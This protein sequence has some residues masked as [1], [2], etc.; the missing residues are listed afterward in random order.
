[1][2]SINRKRVW[3]LI[4]SI[5]M[6]ASATFLL[7]SLLS[8]PPTMAVGP[9]QAGKVHCLDFEEYNTLEKLVACIDDYMPY[10]WG[11]DGR[12]NRFDVPEKEEILQWRK[13]I[14]RMMTDECNIDLSGYSWGSDFTVTTFTDSAPYCVLMETTYDT[15]TDTYG[16]AITRFTHGWGTFIYNR[17]YCRDL[18]ISAPH[19]HPRDERCT[20]AEA[21]GIFKNTRSRTFLMA[22]THR[23]ANNELSGCCQ[24]D[25]LE[26]DSAHNITHTFHAT[27]E[28]LK[29]Y[30]ESQNSSFYHLQFHG[31][32]SCCDNCDVYLSHG[33][34]TPPK[35]GDPILELRDNLLVYNPDW[36]IGVPGDGTCHLNGTKNV[37][38]RLLNGVP[39]DQICD[40]DISPP[41]YSGRFIHIEQ[42]LSDTARCLVYRNPDNWFPAINNTWWEPHLSVTKRASPSP[43]P[44]KAKMT[45]ILRVTNTGEACASG[46][47]ITDVLPEN[48][49]FVS[50]SDGGYENNGVITWS[51]LAVASNASLPITFAVR[52]PCTAGLSITND[53]YRVVT[54]TQGITTGWGAPVTTTITTP[55]IDVSF[56]P[57]STCIGSN[58]LITFIGTSTT[59]GGSIVAWHWD[60][61]DGDTA[62]SSTVSH[63][64]IATGTYTITLTVMDTCGFS[65]TETTASAVRVGCCVYLPTVMKNSQ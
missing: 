28:A 40:C 11:E 30:Y 10:R 50:A 62:T 53:S 37:Q 21:I 46:I 12:E 18:N 41:G 9:A 64:Y 56:S 5:L 15:Y 3:L 48:T 23:R 42:C 60:F 65:Q 38:G 52:V 47:V 4:L 13:V 43:V 27:I 49:Q 26:A 24:D 7:L 59:N 32:E 55:T 58:Q 33:V 2:E 29:W 6:A 36:R 39:P 8:A 44:A 45:C 17:T 35:T 57:A 19:A 31:M 16:D 34:I 51:N 22:G 14:T 63:S 1:M 25:Y 61:G 20:A 54:S